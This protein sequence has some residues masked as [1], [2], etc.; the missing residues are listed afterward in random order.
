MAAVSIVSLLFTVALLGLG[1]FA[2]FFLY[3]SKNLDIYGLLVLG[4]L[5]IL[6]FYLLGKK[7][8]V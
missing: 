3:G 2:N 4:S 7:L 1:N 5:A 8:H 6:V